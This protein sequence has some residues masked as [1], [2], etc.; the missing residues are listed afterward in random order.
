[1]RSGVAAIAPAAIGVVVVYT[2]VPKL[3]TTIETLYLW[4]NPH[5]G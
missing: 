5:P 4:G 2:F 3:A 1:M